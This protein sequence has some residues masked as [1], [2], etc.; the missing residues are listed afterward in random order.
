MAE[1]NDDPVPEMGPDAR[2]RA[3]KIQELDKER[4]PLQEGATQYIISKRQAT[5]SI[6][7]QSCYQ[8][9]FICCIAAL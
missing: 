2:E 3:E 4:L 1:S 8:L 5:F 7:I 9:P 6:I